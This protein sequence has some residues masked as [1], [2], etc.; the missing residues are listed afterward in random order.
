MSNKRKPVEIKYIKCSA[1]K[2]RRVANLVRRRSVD[3]GLSILRNLP[4]KSARLLFKAVHSARA[5]EVNNHSANP[6]LLVISKLLVNEGP[7]MKRHRAR[8]RGRM[9]QI[10]K[11]TSHI[12]VEL[13]ERKGVA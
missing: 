12:V 9:F 10:L 5:N 7:K 4:H 8:A 13:E 2:I 3:D 6:S 11:P 1:H